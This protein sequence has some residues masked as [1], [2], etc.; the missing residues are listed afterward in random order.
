M[1]INLNRMKKLFLVGAFILSFGALKAQNLEIGGQIGYGIS[2]VA[3][4][5]TSADSRGV[6]HIG[7][8]AQYNFNDRWSLVGK[9]HYDQKGYGYT[10][11]TSGKE[12]LA[13]LDIPVM[14]K[15]H[16]GGGDLRGY[17]QFGGYGGVLLSA[18]GEA[19]SGEEVDTKEAYK[20]SDFGLAFGIGL[21]YPLSDNLKLFAELEVNSG[22][23]NI[24]E[25]SP[26][27]IRNGASKLG[28]GVRYALN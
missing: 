9:I 16:F 12:T 26:V 19:P 14:A 27:T 15:W 4:E 25:Q 24:A 21:D 28:L 18:K 23:S 6:F 10:D 3:A 20:S 5:E 17:L 8:L 2:N 7:A 11:G 1:N 22:L 13:Y